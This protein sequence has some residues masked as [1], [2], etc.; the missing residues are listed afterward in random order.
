V[1]PNAYAPYSG[2]EATE[3]V[4]RVQTA[5][6]L[7]GIGCYWGPPEALRPLLSLNPFELFEWDADTVRGVVERHAVLLDRLAG[8]DVALFDL[9]GKAIGRPVADLLGRWV[10]ESVAVYNSSLY[11]EDLLTPQQWEGLAY[12][13]GPPPENPAEMVARKAA[14]LLARPDGIRIYKIKV[15]RVKW[16]GSFEAALERDI[17]VVG[18]VRRVMGDGIALFV[19]GNNGYRS[20]PLAAAD[21]ALATAE[22]EIFAMEE[23]FDEEMAAEAREVKRRLRTAG[24]AIKLADGETHHG[25]IPPELLAERFVGP[26]GSEEPLY[27]ID[28]PDMNTT[29][30]VRMMALVQTCTRHGVT[31]APHNFGSKLGFYSQVH[32]GLVTPNWEFSEA[33]DSAFPALR[34]DGF[35]LEN[36]RVGL[37]GMPGLGVTLDEAHLDRPVLDLQA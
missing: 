33:D 29:G 27:D 13:R 7:E 16:M 14:W 31:V 37:T 17:A 23:M 18:A 20:H 4:L 19:D 2:Y 30:Y 26:N 6:G 28:Q 35:R 1:A 34:G 25:G 10:R 15:G 21:F 24:I 32:V 12:L 9:L 5:Q 8:A 36:G 3:P 11:M 22:E